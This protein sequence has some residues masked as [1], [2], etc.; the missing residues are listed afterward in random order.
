MR[1]NRRSENNPEGAGSAAGDPT[2][3]IAPAEPQRSSQG[4]QFTGFTPIQ[5]LPSIKEVT[6]QTQTIV[7]QVQTPQPPIVEMQNVA[8]PQSA[9]AETVSQTVVEP[10][11]VASPQPESV[12]TASQPVVETQNV[13]SQQPETVENVTTPVTETFEE[14]WGKMVD[15]IFQKKP[16]FYH[17]LRDYLPRYENDIIYVDVENDFQKNQ[18]EMSKRAMLEYWRNQFKLNVDDI[19]FIIHEHERKKVIYTSED[20][21]ENMLEQ[22]PE[23]KDFLQVL[24]FRIKD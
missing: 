13:A 5:P 18:L 3:R 4:L 19:E 15:V 6:A 9:P 23:L 11:N 16:A 10:Q 17:Q 22:N 14:C 1:G 8:T 12:E 24:N 21:V 7:Q 2:A 20:K